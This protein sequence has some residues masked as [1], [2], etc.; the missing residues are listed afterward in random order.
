MRV[1]VTP[2]YRALSEEAAAVVVKSVR[3]KPRLTLGLP[4]G[5]T[6]LGM[7][8][9]L[10]RKHRPE[11]LDFSEVR[12]FNLDEYAGL[13]PDDPRSYHSYMK[14]HFFNHI[15]VA[16]QNTRI[17]DGSPGIDTSVECA[18]YENTIRQCGGIDLLIMGIGTNGHIAFNEPGS[19]FESRTRLVELAGETIQKAGDDMPRRAITM[20][21][22]TM[23]EASRILLLASGS[24]KADVLRRA[25]RGPITEAVPASALQRHSHLMVIA[26]QAAAGR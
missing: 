7:Y 5:Q 16:P 22:A 1:L 21:I 10:I 12:T 23:L 26:D 14:S 20:G 19:S 9:E 15:N 24:N 18:Q 6:P 17:P 3:S 13:L 4:T 2:D 11:G 8:E 25:L